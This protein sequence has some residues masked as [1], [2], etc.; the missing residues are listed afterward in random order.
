MYVYIYIYTSACLSPLPPSLHPS[1][2][3]SPTIR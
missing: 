1:L 2:P 3:L